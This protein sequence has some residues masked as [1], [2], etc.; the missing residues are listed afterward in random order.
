[1]DKTLNHIFNAL[2]GKIKISHAKDVKWAESA[3]GVQMADIDASEARA[4][5]GVG[6]TELPAPGLGLLKHD[7]YLNPLSQHYPNI[8]IIIEHLD[9][10]D[11]PKAFIDKTLPRNGL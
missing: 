5:R 6:L 9:E 2:A 11:V 8:L 7:L 3:M 10:S 4:L 1:M